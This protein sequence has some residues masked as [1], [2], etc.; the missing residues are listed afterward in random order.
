MLSFSDSEAPIL[1]HL[2]ETQMHL[3]APT[4]G[5]AVILLSTLWLTTYVTSTDMRHRYKVQ[6][7]KMFSEDI[8]A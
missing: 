3:Q 8:P 1:N 4:S 5:L 6:I 7:L 2:T